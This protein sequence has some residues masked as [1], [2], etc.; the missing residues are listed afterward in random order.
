[1]NAFHNV[2]VLLFI[3]LIGLTA[4]ADQ[5]S[6]KGRLDDCFTDLSDAAN[7]MNSANLSGDPDAPSYNQKFSNKKARCL[8]IQKSYEQKYGKYTMPQKKRESVAQNDRKNL[9][10]IKDTICMNRYQLSVW[11]FKT[12]DNNYK[13]NYEGSKRDLAEYLARYKK[14]S[15]K[16]FNADKECDI[17]ADTADEAA[18][19]DEI[20]LSGRINGNPISADEIQGPLCRVS[21]SLSSELDQSNKHTM[22]QRLNGFIALYKKKTKKNFDLASCPKANPPQ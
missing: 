6:E 12:N 8:E 16:T 17:V 13:E 9:S 2:A 3:T 10:M 19:M 15:G 7:Q 22:Q 5:E 18:A 20:Q 14:A 11:K 1:M 4:Y 21:A